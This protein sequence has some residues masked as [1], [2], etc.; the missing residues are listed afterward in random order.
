MK[1]VSCV[2]WRDRM[3][4]GTAM[5]TM[6]A[7]IATTIMISSKLKPEFFFIRSGELGK[8][9]CLKKQDA[10]RGVVPDA[11]SASWRAEL[12]RRRSGEPAGATGVGAP[13]F[14]VRFPA[15][16]VANFIHARWTC[17]AAHEANP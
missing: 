4:D 6:S 3:Y 8:A 9:V 11:D 17:G 12:R 2:N 7:M 10:R 13:Q 5:T 16:I 14:A 1:R 15:S